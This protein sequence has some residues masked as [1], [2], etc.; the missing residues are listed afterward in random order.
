M[1]QINDA[2]KAELQSAHGMVGDDKPSAVEGEEAP[3]KKKKQTYSW[4]YEMFL[5]CMGLR[6]MGAENQGNDKMNHSVLRELFQILDFKNDAVDHSQVAKSG[7][8]KKGDK[9][10][11]AQTQR[12]HIGDGELSKEEVYEF[13]NLAA[14]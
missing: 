2:F 5:E 14:G 11:Q 9:K 4:S 6:K 13:I 12:Q 3:K 1:W 10:G 8:G 7:K